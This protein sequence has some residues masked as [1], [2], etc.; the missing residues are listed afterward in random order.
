MA[1]SVQIREIEYNFSNKCGANCFICS[2]PH[3]RGN[4]PL[5]TDE[6]FEASL[7]QLEDI[8]FDCIQTSGNGD[9]FMHPNW[10]KWV[11]ILRRRFPTK[12]ICFYSSFAPM[13]KET[14]DCLL[15]M[16]IVD[17]VYTRLDSLDPEIISRVSQVDGREVLANMRYFNQARRSVRFVVGVSNVWQYYH[18]CR[19]LLGKE[20]YYSPFT[21]AEVDELKK[22]EYG[23]AVLFFKACGGPT[24][25]YR[26]RQ[27]LWAE[28]EDPATPRDEHHPCPKLAGGILESTVWICPDGRLDVCGYDDEQDSLTYGNILEQPIAQLWCS[29]KR[30]ELLGKIER[31]ELTGYPCNSPKACRMYADGEV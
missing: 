31:R 29:P 6:V 22:D 12:K 16:G 20:P 10:F 4:I 15:D 23:S 11:E 19:R 2:K 1:K 28:R 26:I 21:P 7:E 24:T 25:T 3:G 13:D 17:E 8:D 30:A 18:K 14:T 27:S 5:M 9:G